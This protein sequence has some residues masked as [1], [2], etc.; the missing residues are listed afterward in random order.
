MYAHLHIFSLCG[1]CNRIIVW[2]GAF[3]GQGGARDDGGG[4]GHPVLTANYEWLF[5]VVIYLINMT[6]KLNCNCEVRCK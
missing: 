2:Q 4:R 5:G 6:I 1:L 3:N